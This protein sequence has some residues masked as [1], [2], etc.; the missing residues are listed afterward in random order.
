MTGNTLVTNGD[1]NDLPWHYD[2][3]EADRFF[4]K[5][6]RKHASYI[7]KAGASA[8]VADLVQVA[9]MEAPATCVAVPGTARQSA[10]ACHRRNTGPTSPSWVLHRSLPDGWCVTI[11]ARNAGQTVTVP[12]ASRVPLTPTACGPRR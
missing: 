11:S 6:M 10:K 8:E 12:M 9:V 7:R 1:I 5:E 4:S 2:W 3:I